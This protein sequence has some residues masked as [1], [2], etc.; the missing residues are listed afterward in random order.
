MNVTTMPLDERM[1]TAVN[2]DTPPA[3]L[4]QLAG[5]AYWPVRIRVA[6]QH[7]HPHPC[8]R[9][10]IRRPGPVGPGSRRLEPEHTRTRARTARRRPD[11]V[12]SGR[13]RGEPENARP[14]AR[15]ARLTHQSTKKGRT[16]WT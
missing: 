3:V 15:Q 2:P 6:P 9:Q 12:G 1:T 14:C 4:E 7:E 10:V 5:D 13:G 8:A 16:R 11:L